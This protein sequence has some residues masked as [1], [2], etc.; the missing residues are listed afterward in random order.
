MRVRNI[1]ICIAGGVLRLVQDDEGMR[2]RAPA[3]EG[4]RGDLDHA[5]L[6]VAL[7]LGLRAARR[8]GRRRAG[9]DRGRPSR[10]RSPGRK[11]SR[12][13]ASTAGRDSTMRS[14]VP[15]SRHAPRGH[16]EVGLARTGRADAEHELDPLQGLDVD[17]LIGR[18][19]R[20]HPAS[21]ADLGE[22]IA[23]RGVVRG[24]SQDAVDVAGTNVLALPDARVELL[25]HIARRLDRARGARLRHDVAV[26]LRL[27]AEPLLQ[28]RQMSI[29]FAEQPV[30]MPVV[31]EGTTRRPCAALTCLPRPVAA[32]P[33][34]PVK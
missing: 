10:C 25:E 26:R 6:E 4:E 32:G 30:Q 12:S 33:R 3:H 1:F 7:H 29:V 5:G 13:P 2:Q 22:P 17:A 24:R 31:L 15:R 27:D 14:T 20:D 34:T 23:A 8:R 19:R 28:E 16:G 9:A 11:P 21:R 18:A